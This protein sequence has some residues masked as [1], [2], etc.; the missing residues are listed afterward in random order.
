VLGRAKENEISF[1][2]L[3]LIHV[4]ERKFEFLHLLG[5]SL[6]FVERI[7]GKSYCACNEDVCSLNV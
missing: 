6:G 5:S 3:L 7:R 2:F 1:N 4:L